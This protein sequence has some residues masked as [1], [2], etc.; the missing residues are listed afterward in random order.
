[1]TAVPALS[2]GEH[3]ARC[4][5]HEDTSALD[6]CDRCGRFCCPACVDASIRQ[7]RVCTECAAA[8]PAFP[9]HRRRSVRTAL[10]SWWMLMVHPLRAFEA[11]RA[12]SKGLD[13]LALGVGCVLMAFGET[14]GWVALQRLVAWA[15]GP[16]Q[17]PEWPVGLPRIAL[18][19]AGFVGT[20]L[21]VLPIADGAV[22]ALLGAR[23]TLRARFTVCAYALAPFAIAAV[24]EIKALMPL[25][26]SV[27]KALGYR[28]MEGI[29]WP[30]AI[31]TSVA[32]TL[33]AAVVVYRIWG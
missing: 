14:V 19:H 12:R 9:W 6:V 16:V 4:A 1:M 5:R 17:A 18:I 3:S 27:Y 13:G 23:S 22:L 26:A 25:A 32:T 8:I 2:S 30:E 24:P 29:G 28:R 31:I 20:W 15:G 10:S 33:F 21:V 7:R 11:I